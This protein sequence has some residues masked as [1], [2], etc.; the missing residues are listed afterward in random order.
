MSIWMAT[1]RAV[2]VVAAATTGRFITSRAFISLPPDK[3]T[4]G[5]RGQGGKGGKAFGLTM[6]KE[7]EIN[8]GVGQHTRREVAVS[9]V[10]FDGRV[11]IV[12]GAGGGLGRAHALLL[13]SRGAKVV[14]ND[15]GGARDGTGTG[16]TM[17]EQVV[18]EIRDSGGEAVADFHGVDT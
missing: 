10:R 13:A 16:T 3:R 2:V 6:R 8:Y 5:P 14:V 9:E 4:V 15:L 12:T 17:A 11:A 18:K 1:S 7:C